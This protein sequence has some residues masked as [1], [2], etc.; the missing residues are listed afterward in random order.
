M[1]VSFEGFPRTLNRT[2]LRPGRWFVAG[3]G[4][5]PL[6]C[7]ATDLPD[8]ADAMAL[9]FGSPRPETI[10]VH[11]ALI[12]HMTGPFATVEDELVFAPGLGADQKPLLAAPSRRA[13]RPGS[14]LRLV[15]GD[16]GIGFE[17]RPGGPLLVVSLTTG[18]RAEGFDLVFERWSLGLRRGARESVLGYFKPF[19]PFAD[20]RRRG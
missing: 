17:T 4:L 10:E 14:L 1:P 6:L 19:S 16:L 5:R 9:T 12:S 3:D 11:T 7:F 18:Q 8:P 15:S 20:E 2:A 13:F